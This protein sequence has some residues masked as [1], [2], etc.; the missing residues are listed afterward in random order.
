MNYRVRISKILH[1][2]SMS[3]Q[4][5]AKMQLPLKMLLNVN[6]GSFVNLNSFDDLG[7]KKSKVE[8]IIGFLKK[9][10]DCG[11]IIMTGA[12]GDL[13]Y[14]VPQLLYRGDGAIPEIAQRALANGI[15][16]NPVPS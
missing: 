13:D 12:F 8:A 10:E 3:S 16:V 9:Y 5:F 4:D 6:I 7:N 1:A 2:N 14:D 11:A 15:T